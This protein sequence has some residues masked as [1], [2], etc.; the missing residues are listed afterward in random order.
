MMLKLKLEALI[1]TIEQLPTL[2]DIS[3]ETLALIEADDTSIDEMSR[4][5]ERDQ[6]L[7]LQVLKYA[8]S[9][10]AG[11]TSAVSSIKHAVVIMGLNEVKTL[12]LALTLQHFFAS[13]GRD[14][15]NRRHFWKHS[16]ICSHVANY[17]ARSFQ[18]RA[19]ST[20]F[21]SALIHDIGKI[22]VDQYLHDEFIKVVEYIEKNHTTFNEAEKAILGLTHYQIGAKLLRQW[23]FPEQII[24]QVYHHHAPWLDQ[25]YRQGATI[26][27]L[28]NILTKM[29]GFSCL[30]GEK[31]LELAQFSTSKA[32][33]FI[34]ESGFPLNKELLAR[35]LTDI[36]HLL[37]D[38]DDFF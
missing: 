13:S 6:A 25:R 8:N 9:P 35:L 7:A 22:V 33:R 10:F 18:L 4:F 21:I 38:A 37:Q 11:T 23:S 27:Y 15:E 3:T 2:S 16:L 29:A 34:R 36:S 17:L 5:I 32:M 30:A 14:K 12:L 19:D 28:A 31:K 24:S 26:L 20:V 1:L